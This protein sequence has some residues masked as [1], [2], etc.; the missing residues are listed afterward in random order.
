MSCEHVKGARDPRNMSHDSMTSW[1][2]TLE[3]RRYTYLA[4]LWWIAEDII[5][6][7]VKIAFRVVQTPEYR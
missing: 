4:H 7:G 2:V 3:L 5:I 6:V 1:E